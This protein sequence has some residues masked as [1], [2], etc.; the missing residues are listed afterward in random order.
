[1][2]EVIVTNSAPGAIGPYSQGIK[3]N[4]M[5]FV[6]GQL[7]IDPVSGNIAA[8]IEEQTEQSIKNAS[9]ILEAAGLGL[10]DVVKT[11]VFITDLNDFTK[12]NEVYAGYFNE[13]YPARSTVE[14]SRLA[15]DVM[16]EIEMI[17][18]G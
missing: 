13:P 3:G 11:T 16:V 1:M 15:R 4:N 9:A 18:V 7:P 14:I 5:V 6:S 2:K 17:A 10:S 12:M 8:T